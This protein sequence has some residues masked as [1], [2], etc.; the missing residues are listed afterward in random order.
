MRSRHLSQQTKIGNSSNEAFLAYQDYQENIEPV[1]GT[2][3]S[4]T[5]RMYLSR[6][7]KFQDGQGVHLW[8][9]FCP[10]THFCVQG[11]MHVFVF[12]FSCTESIS[13]FY[14]TVNSVLYQSKW[15]SLIEIAFLICMLQRT[16]QHTMIPR[17][18]NLSCSIFSKDW[19]I[20]YVSLY[21]L[22]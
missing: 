18:W 5:T 19:F 1:G 3:I 9:L 16:N 17:F 14:V 22:F 12:N 4:I 7:A 10:C 13:L 8:A 15:A 20:F 2:N 11:L 21:A 6:T